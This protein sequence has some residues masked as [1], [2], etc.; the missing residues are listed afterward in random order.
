MKLRICKTHP[1]ARVP[2]YATASAACFD[3]Y[4]ATVDGA[5]HLGRHVD[6]WQPVT[7]GTGLQFEIPD[8]HVMLIYSRSGHGFHHRVGL[9]N[10][11]AVIDADFRGEVMVQLA[12]HEDPGDHSLGMFVQPGD[13]IAQA[14]IVAAPRVEFEVAEQLSITER[15]AG[16]F[17]STGA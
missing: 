1:N 14:R 7:C 5:T 11:V 10:A 4:A 3:L 9:S 15:G 12:T 2:Q 16:G 17:G 8:G 13:R 6:P